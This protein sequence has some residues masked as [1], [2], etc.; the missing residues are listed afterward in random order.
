[1]IRSQ[2]LT[3]ATLVTAL[4]AAF[5]SVLPAPASAAP[6]KAERTVVG[7][8]VELPMVHV[9]GKRAA[10]RPAVELPRVEVVVTR[11]ASEPSRV[12]DKARAE[13]LRSPRG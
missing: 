7:P 8:V 4:A 9:V 5:V 11:R 3:A 1:M 6:P 10:P 2:T 12:A 13:P